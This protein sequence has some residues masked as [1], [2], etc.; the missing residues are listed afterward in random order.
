MYTTRLSID[1]DRS[2]MSFE[3]VILSPSVAG[4]SFFL[5]HASIGLRPNFPPYLV[6]FP[7]LSIVKRIFYYLKSLK[8]GTFI[9]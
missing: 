6:A 7:F 3:E 5:S 9:G 8:S 4:A 1:Y 2:S